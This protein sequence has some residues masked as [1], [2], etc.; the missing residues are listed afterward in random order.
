MAASCDQY[1]FSCANSGCCH[2]C[3]GLLRVTGK[4][5]PISNLGKDQLCAIQKYVLVSKEVA[6]WAIVTKC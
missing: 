5:E 4:S 3:S 6:R 1:K 2:L